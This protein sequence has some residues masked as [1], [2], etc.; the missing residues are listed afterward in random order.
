MH[1]GP[2]T[3]KAP[4]PRVMGCFVDVIRGVLTPEREGKEGKER[5]PFLK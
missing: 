5:H 1:G 2:D 4:I 3:R